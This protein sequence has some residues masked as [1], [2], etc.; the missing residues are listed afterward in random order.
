MALYHNG[1]NENSSLL[2]FRQITPR[3]D[4]LTK[5]ARNMARGLMARRSGHE[6]P[7][8]HSIVFAIRGVNPLARQVL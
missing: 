2:R 8:R 6:H 7:L 5:A 1:L 3:L 4:A